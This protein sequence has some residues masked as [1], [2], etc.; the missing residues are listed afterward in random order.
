MVGVQ[1][2][3]VPATFHNP[4]YKAPDPA[5]ANAQFWKDG[6]IF[7]TIRHGVIPIPPGAT[8]PPPGT[9]PTMPGYAHAINEADAWAI[10]AYVRALQESHSGKI[11]DIP[12]QRR[13]ALDAERVE[14]IKKLPPEP[15]PAPAGTPAQPPAG[16]KS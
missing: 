13:Q 6:Y 12:A 5:D 4:K 14:L 15:P 9:A 16:G 2:Q 10:V 7:K 3:P 1:I 8:A 11:E